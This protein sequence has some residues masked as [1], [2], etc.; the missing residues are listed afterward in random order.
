M[1][2]SS[3]QTKFMVPSYLLGK[4]LLAFVGEGLQVSGVLL[5][6]LFEVSGISMQVF[7]P[8]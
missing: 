8:F 7:F 1:E 5:A 3:I 2:I 6:V 4:H